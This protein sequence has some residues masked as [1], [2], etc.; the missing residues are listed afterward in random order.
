MYLIYYELFRNRSKQNHPVGRSVD[1]NTYITLTTVIITASSI[2][3]IDHHRGTCIR[4]D[5]NYNFESLF[6]YWECREI[7]DQTTHRTEFDMDP[8]K[9]A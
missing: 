7:D 6:G 9:S 4:S 5:D 1:T 8:F 3:R 2:N